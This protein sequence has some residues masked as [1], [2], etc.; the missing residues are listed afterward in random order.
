MLQ[1]MLIAWLINSSDEIA[2]KLHSKSFYV[3]NGSTLVIIPYMR[4]WI[5]G[6]V[7]SSQKNLD[8]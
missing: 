6:Q 7:I 3:S 8:N 1:T 2:D 5:G 4:V